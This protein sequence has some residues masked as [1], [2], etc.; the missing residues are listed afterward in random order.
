MP[1]SNVNKNNYHL[2]GNRAVGETRRSR[3]ARVNNRTPYTPSLV[4]QPMSNQVNVKGAKPLGAVPTNAELFTQPFVYG[5]TAFALNALFRKYKS[6]PAS[7]WPL[8]KQR[9]KLTPLDARNAAV[10]ATGVAMAIPTF[11][12]FEDFNDPDK[13]TGRILYGIGV[14]IIGALGGSIGAVNLILRNKAKSKGMLKKET[15]YGALLAV[16]LALPGL[17]GGNSGFKRALP[18]Y[19]ATLAGIGLSSRYVKGRRD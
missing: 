17:L 3:M 1:V 12:A 16:P 8:V 9:S 19:A 4:N 11:K 6:N 5:S 18:A 10:L 13:E 15:G 2:L 14:P 7:V